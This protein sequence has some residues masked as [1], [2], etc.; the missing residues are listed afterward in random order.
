MVLISVSSSFF[1]FLEMP[2]DGTSLGLLE[3]EEK[4]AMSPFD[5]ARIIGPKLDQF[6]S[7]VAFQNGVRGGH[8]SSVKCPLRYEELRLWEGDGEAKV[9]RNLNWEIS[10]GTPASRWA[11]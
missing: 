7:V 2:E 8:G 1:F 3:H 6:K 5:V 11:F 9:S 4:V 10:R